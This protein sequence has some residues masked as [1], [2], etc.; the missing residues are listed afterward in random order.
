MF[1]RQDS[2]TRVFV[3]PISAMY[4]KMSTDELAVANIFLFWHAR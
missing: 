3:F 2:L 1:C 4:T